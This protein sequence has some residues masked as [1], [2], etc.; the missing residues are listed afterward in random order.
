MF[1]SAMLQHEAIGEIAA[2]LS[3]PGATRRFV[4]MRNGVPHSIAVLLKELL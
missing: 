4:L 3:A 2:L 1:M